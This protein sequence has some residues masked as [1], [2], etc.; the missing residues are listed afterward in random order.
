MIGAII[1]I[2]IKNKIIIKAAK[3][4]LFC[5]NK[6]KYSFSVSNLRFINIL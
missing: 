5:F 2:I 1:A 3:V 6:Y 4:N